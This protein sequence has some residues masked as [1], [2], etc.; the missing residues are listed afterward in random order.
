[1]ATTNF[2][3][4]TN[5]AADLNGLVNSV[6]ILDADMDPNHVLDRKLPWSVRVKWQIS[7]L[8]APG[9]GGDWTIRVNLE[10]LGAGFEGTLMTVTVPVSDAIPATVRHYD[11]TISLPKPIATPGLIAG[12][13]KPVIIITH[14]NT[15]GGVSKRTR[16]AGFYEAYMVDF[17]DADV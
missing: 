6:E 9:I 17:I 2:D 16:M 13:Y 8:C 14:T 3:T 7:G 1:M 12:T 5:V 4:L 11:K 10:S 15:G